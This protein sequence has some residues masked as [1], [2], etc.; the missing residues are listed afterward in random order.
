MFVYGLRLAYKVFK[1]QNAIPV[2]SGAFK[3]SF[4][5]NTYRKN[6]VA[7][8]FYGKLHKMAN[9]AKNSRLKT[10]HFS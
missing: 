8:S 1:L 3:F 5:V 4:K 6:S 2:L 9:I 10:A 7:V